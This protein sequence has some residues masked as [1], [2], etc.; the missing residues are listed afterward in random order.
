MIAEGFFIEWADFERDRDALAAVRQP[1][2]IDEQGVPADLVWD[3][4][5]AQSQHAL[6]RDDQGTPIGAGRLAPDFKIGRMA[7]LPDW[8]NRGVGAALLDAL[9][10]R[11]R[12]RRGSEV[13]LHAQESAVDFYQRHG[14]V[15]EGEPFIEA[16]IPHR[17]MRLS[18]SALPR[19]EREAPPPLVATDEIE[20]S[21]LEH[22]R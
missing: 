4:V 21:Q 8:R 13:W 2:F 11:A 18:L 5:D 6:A 14:F 16:D 3:A 12:A 20:F 7:V 10:D 19:L 9:I 15:A 22:A 17:L 1:V